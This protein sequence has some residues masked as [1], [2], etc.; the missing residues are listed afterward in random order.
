[1]RTAA[2]IALGLA[3]STAATLPVSAQNNQNRPTLNQLVAQDEAR[4]AQLKANLRLNDDQLS[5]WG[6]LESTL[7][8]IAKKR[9]ERRIALY[10]EYDKR[11]D[12][13]KER[14][15]TPAEILRK[16]A[17]A[18]TR[19]ADELRAIADASEPLYA[20]FNDQQ[21]R[22]VDEIIRGFASAPFI[23]GDPRMRGR[24]YY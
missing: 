24:R 23:D 14:A 17:D 20:K 21:R 3:L 11:D 19:R 9:A 10:D 4:I 5:E 1:M 15:F 16:Q 7:K 8:D 22:R 2:A 13:E 6:R 12:K 18:L